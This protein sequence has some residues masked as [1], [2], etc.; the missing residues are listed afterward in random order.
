MVRKVLA[1][2]AVVSVLAISGTAAG[3]PAPDSEYPP[4]FL[5]FVKIVNVIGLDPA[6]AARIGPAAALIARAESLTAYAAAAEQRGD[7]EL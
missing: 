7:A 3:Q 5:D 4:T 2:L 1:V 6:T